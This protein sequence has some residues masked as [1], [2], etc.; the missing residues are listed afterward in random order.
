MLAPRRWS[1]LLRSGTD[2]SELQEE[3]EEVETEE[4]KVTESEELVSTAR[5][6]LRRSPSSWCRVTWKRVPRSRAPVCL[7]GDIMV[8]LGGWWAARAVR[9]AVG[10]R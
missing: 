5:S 1:R 4:E 7:A 10:R 2:C 6:S 8:G 9:W 3:Q